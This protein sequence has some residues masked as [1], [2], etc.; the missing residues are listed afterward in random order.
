MSRFALMMS[1]LAGDASAAVNLRSLL[2]R[3]RARKVTA[4]R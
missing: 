2:Y 3:H 4:T 1:L